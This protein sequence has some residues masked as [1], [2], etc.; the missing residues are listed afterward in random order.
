[1]PSQERPGAIPAADFTPVYDA[2]LMAAGRVRR[3]DDLTRR[4]A[5]Q[6]VARQAFG[7]ESDPIRISPSL[8]C[9]C[10]RWVGYELLG[11]SPTPRTADEE[12]T[13]LLGT[14]FH[15]Q[16][17]NLFDRYCPEAEQERGFSINLGPA[18]LSG[19]ADFLYR[20][21]KTGERILVELKTVSPFTWSKLRTQRDSSAY[22][23]IAENRKQLL[24][25]LWALSQVNNQEIDIGVIYYI[26]RTS[27]E[28]RSAPVFWDEVAKYD[29]EQLMAKIQKAGEALKQGQL[30]EPSVESP[31]ICGKFCQYCHYCEYGQRFAQGEIKATKP[32]RP[33]SVY[34][35]AKKQAEE[36]RQKLIEL[37]VVQPTLIGEEAYDKLVRAGGQRPSVVPESAAGY[38]SSWRCPG[39]Q[40]AAAVE[41][42][43]EATGEKGLMCSDC[44][45]KQIIKIGRR[46][47]R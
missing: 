34:A 36:R 26:N 6:E 25:Y 30:P 7:K 27:G 2:V 28:R 17:L 23:P 33:R 14:G 1:M 16:A 10:L 4:G 19:Q 24:L 11:Y 35:I 9:H 8:A 31:F 5:R 32:H 29:A 20:D 18:V 47:H 46:H 15:R 13:M 45:G 44:G 37:G 40:D 21:L 38:Y 12:T 42:E 22:I 3:E 43:I 41:Y 39:H